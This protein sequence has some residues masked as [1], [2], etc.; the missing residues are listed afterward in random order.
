MKVLLLTI[1]TINYNHDINH[2]EPLKEIASKVIRYNYLDRIKK[3]GKRKM[4]NEIIELAKTEKPD[5]VF[6]ITYQDQIT[7]KTLKK[8]R[9]NG[10]KIIGW[11]SDDHWRFDNYSKYISKD[12]FCSITTDPGSYQKY[13]SN[14]INVIKSQWAS[15]PKYYH[16]TENKKKHEV[17]FVGQ[18][19][20]IRKEIMEHLLEKK[21]PL[22]IFGKGWNKYVPFN[23][24]ISIFHNS[25]INI[26]ISASSKNKNLKQ[27]KGRVFEVPMCGG[28]LLTD[29]T[30]GLE[31]YFE[32]GKEIICFSDKDD[33]VKKIKY[34]LKNEEERKI[35]AQNGHQ[36][37]L[38]RNSWKNRFENIFKE[39]KMLQYN[40]NNNLLFNIKCNLGMF[41]YTL[42]RNKLI[43]KIKTII[44]KYV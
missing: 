17:S 37:A 3:I 15:N 10:S 4:N 35:I 20:G 28:F 39:I 41:K 1:G 34:Y 2:Y 29:Y 6:F 18:N 40:K 43:S 22:E 13:K 8:L 7:L 27:I 33:L 26:N 9:H 25:K 24:L 36:A 30:E 5:Y 42:N 19:Y 21:I 12:F 38:N 23:E 11:F 31:D 32:I 44:K 14:N 16:P